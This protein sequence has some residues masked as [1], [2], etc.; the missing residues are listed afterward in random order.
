MGGGACR[1]SIGVGEATAAGPIWGVQA[2]EGEAMATPKSCTAFGAV[3]VLI[4]YV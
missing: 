1:K 3:R 2:P 4:P